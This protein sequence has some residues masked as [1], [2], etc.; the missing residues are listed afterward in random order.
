M[1]NLVVLHTRHALDL[2]EVLLRFLRLM[3]NQLLHVLDRIL[4]LCGLSLTHLELLISLVQLDLEVVDV[5]LGSGQLILSVLQPSVGIIK[6]VGLEVTTA[7]SP[8]QL[9]VQLLD[10]RYNVGI[11]LNKLLV[12]L[13]NVLDG[14]VLGLHLVGV[15]LQ[16]EALDGH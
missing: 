13:L 14:V 2:L 7:I 4:Q 16:A 8:H 15:V 3:G 5:V 11:L 12:T 6:E 10:T 9:I 1:D